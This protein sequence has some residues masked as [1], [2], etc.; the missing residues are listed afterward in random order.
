MTLPVSPSTV[1]T[2]CRTCLGTPAS[3]SCWAS[4]QATKTDSRAGFRITA[5][6]AA[7]AANTLPAGIAYAVGWLPSVWFWRSLMGSLGGRVTFADAARAYY[8]GHLGKYVPGKAMVLVIDSYQF[9]KQFPKSEQFGLASQMQRA[10]VSIPAN[11]AEG[12]ARQHTKG[13]MLK[14][15]ASGVLAILPCSRTSCTLRAPNNGDA[16]WDVAGNSWPCW[17]DFFEHSL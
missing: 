10:A 6:P 4:C 7:K 9:T 15:A 16:L 3:Q 11:M 17:R 14:K 12:Q 8:C 1:G 5:L 2:N 13:G